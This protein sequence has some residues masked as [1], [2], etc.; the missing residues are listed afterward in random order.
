MSAAAQELGVTHGAI[1][2]HIRALEEQFGLLLVRRLPHAVETTP[3]GVHLAMTLT[4]AFN[5]INMAVA[6]VKPMP[7]TLSCSATIMMYWLIP[8]LGRFKSLHPEIDLRLNVSHGD[9]HPGRDE[10]S[11]AIRNSMYQPDDDMVVHRL[12]QEEVGPVCHP[13]YAMQMNLTAIKDI[14]R[15]RI[16]GAKTRANGWHEW[17][18]CSG[19]GKIQVETHESFEHFYLVIQA[20]VCGLGLAMVPRVLVEDEI[21]S[22]HLVAPFG[23]VV[24]PHRLDLWINPHL[25]ARKD[26]RHLI[27]WLDDEMKQMRH[28]HTK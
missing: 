5:Q 10:I 4:D 23:F 27:D 22:G 26:V 7:L 13:D 6:R 1:S 8:R 21:N 9:I 14:T 16:L 28:E 18:A 2:R 25:R 24:G 17:L 11:V 12:I 15:C 19:Y 20:A 3:E